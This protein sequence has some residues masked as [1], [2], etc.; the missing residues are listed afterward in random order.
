MTGCCVE[1]GLGKG[2][3]WAPGGAATAQLSKLED[4]NSHP[5]YKNCRSCWAKATRGRGLLRHRFSTAS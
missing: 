5:Q 1:P 3:P 4:G 2:E